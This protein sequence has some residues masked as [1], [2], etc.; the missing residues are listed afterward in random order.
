MAYTSLSLSL[1]TLLKSSDFERLNLTVLNTGIQ[2]YYSD[3]DLFSL[4]Y[5]FICLLV[6]FYWLIHYLLTETLLV[7][8]FIL[9]S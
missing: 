1:N 4:F 9:N 8:S 7:H 6:K 5:L 3:L 2:H